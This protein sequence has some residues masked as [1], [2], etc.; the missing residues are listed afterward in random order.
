MEDLKE[1][2]KFALELFV[3][4][5]FDVFAI[6]LDFLARSVATALYSFVMG[7]FL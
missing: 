6:Q 5:C 7:F 3:P 1:S 2:K 4:L